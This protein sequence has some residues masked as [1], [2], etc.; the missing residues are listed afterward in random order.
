MM[1]PVRGDLPSGTVTFLFTDVEGSTRLLHEL[2]AEAYAEALAEH[3]RVIR[4]ACARHDGIEVDTQGDAFFFAFP[5]A[6]GALAAASETTEALASGPIQ[7]RIGLHTGTPLLTEEGYAGGDVHRAARI[8]AAGHG[9]QVLVSSSTATLIEIELTDLGEHRLKD[10]SAPERISQLGDSKFPPLRTV[11][12]TNLPVPLTPFLGRDKELAEVGELLGRRDVRLLTLTGPGGTGKT[13]LAAQAAGW[14][15]DDYPYGVWWVPLDTL[16]DPRLVL[17]AAGHALGTKREPSA[18]VGDRRMLILFDCFERVVDGAGSIAGLLGACPNL[19][20]LVTSRERLRVTG[21]HEYVVPSL[22]HEEAIA[23]FSA[24]ARAARHDFEVDEAVSEICRRLDDLPLALELAAAHMKALSTIQLVE[25]GLPLSSRG[26]RDVPDR[27][28]TLRATIE[29]SH[30]LLAEDEQRTFRRLAVFAGGCTLEAA[31]EVAEADIDT[32]E[33][34]VDKSLLRRRAERYR[35]LDTIREYALE[36]LERSGEADETWERLGRE[37]LMLADAEG[38]PMFFDRQESA[39]ARLEPEHA[40]TRAVIEWARRHGQNAVV[41]RLFAALGEVWIAQGH[42]REAVSWIESAVAARHEISDELAVQ[43]LGVAAE[44]AEV[45]GDIARAEALY[46][47]ALARDASSDEVD[48][49]WE[50]AYLVQLSRIALG[51]G[52]RRRAR[53]LAE[54]SLELRLAR[55]LPRARALAWLGEMALREGDLDAAQQ[56][57]EDALSAEEPRHAANDASYCE[58]LG[59]VMRRRGDEDRAR[60]LFHD[61]LR[62]AVRLGNHATAADCLEDLALVANARGQSRMAARLWGTGQAVREVVGAP[63][64]RPRVIGDLPELPRSAGIDATL[65]DAVSYALSE[66]DD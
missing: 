60:E 50:P 29:W 9:G 52:D 40:N 21:E 53:A 54:R 16:R 18:H 24:R 39:F 59:E 35:M 42:Q 61:A 15:A 38:A 41:A 32:L 12:Q 14:A 17:E 33:S 20:V 44:V 45:T 10:L 64:S 7:V 43:A 1:P 48:P 28:R 62:S 19:K 11:R 3:Q 22:V 31:E 56:F 66:T 5:T 13:R 30:D 27:Q 2:G 37:L 4:E 49:F 26:P 46:E 65:E 6:P 58:A 25:R 36:K 8:A 57:L 47:E 23:L 63:P 34:L 51:Q 55:D